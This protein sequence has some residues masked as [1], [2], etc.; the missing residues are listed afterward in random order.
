LIELFLLASFVGKN[1]SIN[2]NLKPYKME[3]RTIVFFAYPSGGKDKHSNLIHHFFKEKSEKVLLINTGEILRNL[4]KGKLKNKI[5]SN[6]KLGHLVPDF[7]VESIVGSLLLS[8]LL[9]N[10]HLILNGFPRNIRQARFMIKIMNFFNRKVDVVFIKITQKEAMKRTRRRGHDRSDDD[11]AILSKR[12]KIFRKNQLTLVPF[13][14][15]HC[16]FIVI[17]GNNDVIK[18]HEDIKTA[19]KIS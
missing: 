14:K 9:D 10:T 16:T 5:N 15:S 19:L 6:I 12:F 11:P 4:K 7:V 3:A 2:I 18:V 8:K 1:N 13:L 17:D